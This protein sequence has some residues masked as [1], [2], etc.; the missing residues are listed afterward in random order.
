MN[1]HSYN[2]LLKNDLYR[3]PSPMAKDLPAQAHKTLII[4]D[5]PLQ[6]LSEDI[7]TSLTKMTEA[8][9]LKPEDVAYYHLPVRHLEIS[10]K[11][12]ASIVV[13]FGWS[14]EQMGMQCKQLMNIPIRL[15][16]RSYLFTNDT[17]SLRSTDQKKQL[18]AGLQA[19]FK[20]K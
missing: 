11:F 18:W 20:L 9:Q 13:V 17:D 5:L 12:G 19:L 7:R 3:I 16:H 2:L 1:N 6:E 14:A 4:L 10:E 15:D 8:L